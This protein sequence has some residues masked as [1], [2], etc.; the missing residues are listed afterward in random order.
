MKRTSPGAC[1]GFT[2]GALGVF[3]FLAMS[4]QGAARPAGGAPQ[5]SLAGG[6]Y[7][8]PQAERGAE[9]Y[10]RKCVSCHQGDLMGDYDCVPPLV[11]QAFL[12]GWKD[13]SL[14]DL[15]RAIRETMP[16][17]EGNRLTATEY[18]DV[19]TYILSANRVPIGQTELQPDAQLL[20]AISMRAGGNENE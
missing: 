20:D 12:L 6:V 19:V 10:A 18:V 11:G 5:A 8:A 1:T 4:G 2:F 16:P 9:T 13:A 17:F 14:G 15:Y 3:G 7:T